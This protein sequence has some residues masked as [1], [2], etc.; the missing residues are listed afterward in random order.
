MSRATVAATA[1]KPS[2]RMRRLLSLMLAFASVLCCQNATSAD[3]GG[4]EPATPKQQTASSDAIQ[5]RVVIDAPSE[6]T[7]VLRNSVDLVR[8]QSYA[9]MTEDLFDRRARDAVA[10]AR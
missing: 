4:S 1:R 3:V 10:Q 7:D 6:F 9:D 2:L 8:W 5:Y